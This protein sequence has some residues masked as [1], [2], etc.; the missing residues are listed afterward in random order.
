MHHQEK[1]DASVHRVYIDSSVWIAMLAQEAN[2]EFILDYL[3]QTSAQII[4]SEW[5]RTELASALGIKARRQEFS[6]EAVSLMLRE[7]ESWK[8][9]GLIVAAVFSHDFELAAQ[10]CEN[11]E[12]KLRCGDALHL[13]VA[14]RSRVSHLLSLD[15]DMQRYA[16]LLGMQMIETYDKKPTH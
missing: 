12:S 16:Q 5:T 4:T 15:K 10:M 8:S 1:M 7:F 11:I 14:Q 6:Q 3:S 2:A 9:A 13:A